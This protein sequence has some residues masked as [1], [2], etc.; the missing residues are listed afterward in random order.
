[1]GIGQLKNLSMT[2]LSVAVAVHQP[3]LCLGMSRGLSSGHQINIDYLPLP[4]GEKSTSAITNEPIVFIELG[5]Q[6]RDKTS[7]MVF[8]K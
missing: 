2:A 6:F 7:W 3:S 4:D 1:M 5:R 8:M